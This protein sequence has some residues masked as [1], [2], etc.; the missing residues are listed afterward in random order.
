[1]IRLEMKNYNTILVEKQPKYQ[2]YLQR[3]FISMNILLIKKYYNLIKKKIEQAQF[4]YSRLGKT[5]EKQIKT[6][7]D[8]GKKS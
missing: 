7:K 5:F 3:K 1:M 8:Q 4:T 6:I 2:R